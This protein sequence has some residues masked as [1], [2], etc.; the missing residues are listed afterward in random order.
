M[1]KIPSAKQQH[2]L[3]YYKNTFPKLRLIVYDDLARLREPELFPYENKA[4]LY[5]RVKEGIMQSLFDFDYTFHHLPTHYKK[6]IMASSNFTNFIKEVFRF[7]K[8]IEKE[9]KTEE[10]EELFSFVLYQN[11]FTIG[12][13]GL[14]ASMPSEFRPYLEDQ[15]KPIMLLMQ[16]IAKYSKRID[17][18]SKIPLPV[19]PNVL[20]GSEIPRSSSL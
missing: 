5:N 10:P 6:E 14:I 19:Y 13:E 3:E 8:D 16:S 18:K 9:Q 15:V 20:I 2:S 4:R 1:K 7:S 11:F 17:P 12:I